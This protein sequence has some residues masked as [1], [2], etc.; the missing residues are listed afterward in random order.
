MKH[1]KKI[2]AALFVAALAPALSGCGASTG[3]GATPTPADNSV[4]G[5]ATPSQISVVTAR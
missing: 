4:T 2:V 5:I 3:S 1:S